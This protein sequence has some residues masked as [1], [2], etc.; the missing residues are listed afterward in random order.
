[1]DSQHK[2]TRY[3][4]EGGCGVGGG[5]GNRVSRERRQLVEQQYE[6]VSSLFHRFAFTT[7]NILLLLNGYCV[8]FHTPV[9]IFTMSTLLCVV[10]NDNKPFDVI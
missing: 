5:G 3:S 2:Q 1:M 9:C 7:L 6:E 4:S 8:R 10:I